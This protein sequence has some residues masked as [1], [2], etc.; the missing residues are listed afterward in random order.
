MDTG[1][2]VI[3]RVRAGMQ[4]LG[5]RLHTT[6]GRLGPEELA[7][8]PNEESNSVGN[9]VVHTCGFLRQR[10]HAGFGGAEDDRTR[11]AEFAARG[12]WTA[13]Q[14]Q[15][16]TASTFAEVDAFLAAL[17]PARLAE[18]RAIQGREVV[19]LDLLLDMLSHV[20]QHVGQIIY[21]A[22]ARQGGAFA[23]LSIPLPRR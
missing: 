1:A 7:W 21:I 13:A 20:G 10:F 2:L 14:L 15:A 18:R 4:T 12:P 19:L 3:A 17:D 5:E 9:L 8:R 23:S 16:L 6:L 11:D 22:K